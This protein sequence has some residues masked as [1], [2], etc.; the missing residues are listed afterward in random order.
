M[1]WRLTILPSGEERK[2]SVRV[3]KPV[4]G[5]TSSVPVASRKACRAAALARADSEF[6]CSSNSSRLATLGRS[7]RPNEPS[8]ALMR[9]SIRGSSTIF[10]AMGCPFDEIGVGSVRVFAKTFALFQCERNLPIRDHRQVAEAQQIVAGL[11][12]MDIWKSEASVHN[13]GRSNRGNL[14]LSAAFV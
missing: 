14:G 7:G 6:S 3:F 11:R 5:A 1:N 12:A 10:E 9:G 4:D 13:C 2:R 8:T